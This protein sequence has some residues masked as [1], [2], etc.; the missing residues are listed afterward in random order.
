MSSGSEPM[1]TRF[2]LRLNELVSVIMYTVKKTRMIST[3]TMRRLLASMPP[4]KIGRPMNAK[5]DALGPARCNSS[6]TKITEPTANNIESLW[7]VA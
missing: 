5:R 3:H 1:S 6:A 4:T 7:V 2:S